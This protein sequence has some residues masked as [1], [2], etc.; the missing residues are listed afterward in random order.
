VAD[1]G[2]RRVAQA[3]STAAR[4]SGQYVADHGGRRVAQATGTAARRTGQYVADHGGRR[5]AQVTGT[6]ARRSGQYVA[7]HGGRRVAGWG[8]AAGRGTARAARE[9]RAFRRE[10]Q[11][12]LRPPREDVR[13]D[14]RPGPTP[15]LPKVTVAM[16][17]RAPRT[18]FPSGFREGPLGWVKAGIHVARHP[19]TTVKQPFQAYGDRH[20][21]RR[22]VNKTRAVARTYG[23]SRWE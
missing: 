11:Y 21:F 9:Q 18:A 19:V 17:S 16:K 3:T 4:R 10:Q 14:Y 5:T 12:G 1:H 13:R 6:A 22:N 8:R 7:D 20:R 2:G 23:L 15:D